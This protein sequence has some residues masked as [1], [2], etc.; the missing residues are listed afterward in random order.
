MTPESAAIA[1]AFSR[2]VRAAGLEVR[3]GQVTEPMMVQVAVTDSRKGG[4]LVALFEAATNDYVGVWLD[5]GADFWEHEWHQPGR[6]EFA[7]ELGGVVVAHV[8]GDGTY[9]KGGRHYRVTVG[10]GSIRTRFRV[11][12]ER[13]LEL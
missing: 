13:V 4:H 5:N 12:R 8:A 11:D 3:S 9:E 2:P 1:E 6:E 10:D 7:A